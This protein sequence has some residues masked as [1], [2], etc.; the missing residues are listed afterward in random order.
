MKKK[1]III[2]ALI[3]VL[4]VGMCIGFYSYSKYP[5]VQ[6]TEDREKQ[7]AEVM[8]GTAWQIAVEQPIE[9]FMVC[10][11]YSGSNEKAGI[12]IFEEQKN[13]N[14]KLIS[15]K[16]QNNSDVIITGFSYKGEKWYD[17]AWFNGAATKYADMIYTIGGEV[18]PYKFETDKSALI[19]NSVDAKE[20]TLDVA[21][22]DNDGN[23]YE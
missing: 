19:Y 17:I 4:I 12:A 10:G 20:Y 5:N 18:L 2:S 13:G 14:Y 6:T 16:I 22:Y 15:R 7:L 11:I 21:Y 23:K 9:N 8:N 3:F 1:N